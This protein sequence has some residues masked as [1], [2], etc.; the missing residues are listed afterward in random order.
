MTTLLVM[1]FFV[2]APG[3][4]HSL[5]RFGKPECQPVVLF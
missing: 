4:A 2:G 5:D 1:A 3:W